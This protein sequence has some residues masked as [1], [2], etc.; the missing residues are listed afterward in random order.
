[1][2]LAALLQKLPDQK[3]EVGKV[4]LQY[5]LKECLFEIPNGN[6]GDQKYAA[7]KCKSTTS[8]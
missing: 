8:R 2:L 5:L 7:P 6:K 1:M 4:L 3:L